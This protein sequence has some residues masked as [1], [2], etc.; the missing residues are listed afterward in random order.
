[1]APIVLTAALGLILQRA[2][3]L[4]AAAALLPDRARTENHS[5]PGDSQRHG[6][7]CRPAFDN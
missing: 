7:V 1:M 6:G 5:E 4:Q 3:M 2:G